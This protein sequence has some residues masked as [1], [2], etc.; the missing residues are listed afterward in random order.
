MVV[1]PPGSVYTVIGE[2]IINK[3]GGPKYKHEKRGAAMTLKKKEFTPEE[4]VVMKDILNK[5]YQGL[6]WDGERSVNVYS[7]TGLIELDF[8]ELNHLE[9]ALEKLGITI[10]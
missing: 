7:D 2:A 1:A 9:L 6:R 3:R 8:R 4:V 10:Y 5:V